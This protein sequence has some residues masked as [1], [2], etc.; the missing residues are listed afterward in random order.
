MKNGFKKPRNNNYHEQIFLKA[1]NP[2][3]IT[4]VKEGIYMDVNEAFAKIFNVR[5]QDVIGKTSRECGQLTEER[6]A[7]LIHDMKEKGHSQSIL[8]F[9]TKNNEVQCILLNT[10][11]MKIDKHVLW[12][13]VGTDIS[14]LKLSKDSRQ[15]DALIKSFDSINDTGVILIG[16][17][18]N[19]QS[20]I[21]YMNEVAKNV[22]EAKS[23]QNL[24]DDLDGTEST[25]IST[26]TGDY[27]VRTISTHVSSPLKIIIMEQFPESKLIEKKMKEQGFTPRQQEVAL[28]IVTGCSNKE[29]AKKLYISENTVKE[30]MKNIF[31]VMGINNRRELFPKLMNLR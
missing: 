24:L 13:S 23:L 3:S 25:F 5:R 6:R 28:L 19:E 22:L 1:P 7:K 26:G 30:H 17:N 14:K 11:P 12:L 4:T 21:F 27:H 9:E 18:K 8:T 15:Y 16:N 10:V 31:S 29:I 2:V 20:Y